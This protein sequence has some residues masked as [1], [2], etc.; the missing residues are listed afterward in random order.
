MLEGNQLDHTKTR[1]AT[2]PSGLLIVRPVIYHLNQ[3]PDL[4]HPGPSELVRMSDA[5]RSAC[6]SAKLCDAIEQM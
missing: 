2:A 6:A 3:T 5:N 4:W 1:S